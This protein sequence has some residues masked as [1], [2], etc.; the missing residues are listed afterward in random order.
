MAFKKDN[1]VKSNFTKITI[2][3][4]SPEEILLNSYGEVLNRKPSITAPISPSVMAFSVSGFSVLLKTTNVL[5]VSISA[6]VT[7]A[8]SA[9][10]VVLR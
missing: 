9:T 1:K 7:K 3:F 4:A 5:V 8:S 10:D 2:G 6:S